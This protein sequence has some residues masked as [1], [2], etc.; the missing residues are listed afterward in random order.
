MTS[1]SDYTKRV[2][3]LLLRRDG[4]ANPNQATLSE[5]DV[6]ARAATAAAIQELTAAVRAATEHDTNPATTQTAPWPANVTA[7]ILTRVGLRSREFID[8]T[9]DIIDTPRDRINTD[10][11][12]TALCRPCGW[13]KENGLTY[14]PTVLEWARE[15]A[16]DCTALPNPNA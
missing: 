12:S 1:T 4:M 10:G 3:T 16:S 9:V 6:N 13:S 5:A 7:R 15:H 11:L 2:D 14:R 8:A